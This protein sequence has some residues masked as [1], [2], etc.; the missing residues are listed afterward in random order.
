MNTVESK[1]LVNRLANKFMKLYLDSSKNLAEAKAT[2]HIETI[3][4]IA[5][6]EVMEEVRFENNTT[7]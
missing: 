5:V 3:L 2:K 1:V 7:S 4:E 6:N